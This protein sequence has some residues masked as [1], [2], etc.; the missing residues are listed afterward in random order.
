MQVRA[1]VLTY[2]LCY[3]CIAGSLS[4]LRHTA[5]ACLGDDAEA[6]EAAQQAGL[7]PG[8]QQQLDARMVHRS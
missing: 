4:E 6:I 3:V 7:L 8:T 1:T 2:L 5:L